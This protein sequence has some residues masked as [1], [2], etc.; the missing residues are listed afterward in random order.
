M[1]V[2]NFLHICVTADKNKTATEKSIAV[3]TDNVLIF[4]NGRNQAVCFGR[5]AGLPVNMP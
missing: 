5:R 2:C 4:L 1:S 3:W